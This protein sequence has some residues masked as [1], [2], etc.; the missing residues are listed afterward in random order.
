MENTEESQIL[1]RDDSPDMM[2]SLSRSISD[3]CEC[4]ELFLSLYKK[5]KKERKKEKSKLEIREEMKPKGGGKKDK[6]N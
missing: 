3:A 6:I 4:V 5:K 1:K 2:I